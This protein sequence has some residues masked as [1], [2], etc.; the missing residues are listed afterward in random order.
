MQKG[1]PTLS[2]GCLRL[3]KIHEKKF[4]HGESGGAIDRK[5]TQKDY[6]PENCEW[7]ALEEN[8]RQA[9]KKV[10]CWGKNLETGEYYEFDNIR[11][12]AKEY[13]LSYSAID[14]VLHKHNKTHKT[15]IFGYLDKT[16]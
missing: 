12:F 7:I 13:G 10:Y 11:K 9:R 15:W 5:N 6:C 16:H 3:E 14:Q 8:S 2:C 1:R 4:I